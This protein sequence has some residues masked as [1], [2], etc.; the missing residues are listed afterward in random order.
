M[1]GDL[2]RYIQPWSGVEFLGIIIDDLEGLHVGKSWSKN[3]TFVEQ[4]MIRIYWLNEPSEKPEGAR[5]QIAKSWHADNQIKLNFIE[6]TN[7]MI[8]EWPRLEAE[9]EWYLPNQFD[10]IEMEET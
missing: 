10:Y 2:I 5:I 6:N 9:Q 7:T 8:D 3:R 1:K 4:P